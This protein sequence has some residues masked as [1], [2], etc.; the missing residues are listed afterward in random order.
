M[1]VPSLFDQSLKKCVFSGVNIE[2]YLINLSLPIKAEVKTLYLFSGLV[3]VGILFDEPRN[4]RKEVKCLCIEQDNKVKYYG[5]H[6]CPQ[7]LTDFEVPKDNKLYR[8]IIY[9]NGM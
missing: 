5:T 3:G 8:K 4:L 7:Y 2:N 6:C 9:R 1:E